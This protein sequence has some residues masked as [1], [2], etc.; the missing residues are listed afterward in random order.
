MDALLRS[1]LGFQDAVRCKVV[2]GSHMDAR[3]HCEVRSTFERIEMEENWERTQALLVQERWMINGR[4]FEDTFEGTLQKNCLSLNATLHHVT[5]VH[6]TPRMD[7]LGFT[8]VYI[9]I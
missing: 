5:L 7:I 1:H 9:C 4:T 3:K 8:L 2:L 6:L